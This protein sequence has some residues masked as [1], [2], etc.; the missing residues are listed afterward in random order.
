MAGDLL[1]RTSGRVVL[2][3]LG[4]SDLV[5]FQEYRRDPEVARYQ[6]WQIVADTEAMSFLAE[7]A[8]AELFRPGHW[9]QIGIEQASTG[10]LIGDIGLR[11]A[12][13]EAEAE[14]GFSLN[15]QAQG[16]GLAA[17]AVRESIRL[18]FEQT[19]VGRLI[20]ITDAR[21]LLAIRLLE[22]MGMHKTGEQET[23]F[24]GEP[25]IEYIFDLSRSHAFQ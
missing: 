7:M 16:M 13:D 11:I 6:G 10:T 8:T 21:N 3:R 24:K 22:R 15:R 1:P 5:E 2:R 4:V 20:A 19:P 17:E 18:V 9:C 14:I 12:A 25:C 23:V